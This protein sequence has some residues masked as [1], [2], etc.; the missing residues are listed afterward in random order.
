MYALKVSTKRQ[1]AP[2]GHCTS[3]W[4][5]TDTDPRI[6]DNL[7]FI[8]PYSQEVN[9]STKLKA[10]PVLENVLPQLCIRGCFFDA[11]ASRA[12]CGNL[13]VA[14]NP[15]EQRKWAGDRICNLTVGS[16]IFKMA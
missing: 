9:L 14:D 7:D 10:N 12:N 11:F 6:F 4:N 15:D 2:Y 16:K 1:P 5:E 8:P 13:K 3:D